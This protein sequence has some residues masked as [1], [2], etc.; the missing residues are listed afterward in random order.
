[1]HARSAWYLLAS[2][3]L[4]LLCFLPPFV[5]KYDRGRI[6]PTQWNHSA[7]PKAFQEQEARFE[8]VARA[9]SQM[10]NVTPQERE[11]FLEAQF[12]VKAR[13]FSG[14]GDLLIPGNDL[15]EERWY[16]LQAMSAKIF[17]S[18]TGT[19]HP[20]HNFSRFSERTFQTIQMHLG[21][22]SFD[23][24]PELLRK[25]YEES[26]P[27]TSLWKLRLQWL[28]E[29]YPWLLVLCALYCATLVSPS[30]ELSL[31]FFKMGWMV[32]TLLLLH[33]W[34]FLERPPVSNMN[35]TLIY[36]PWVLT[37]LV[38]LLRV[39]R[40]TPA[41]QRLVSLTNLL[42]LVGC[43]QGGPLPLDP[44]PPVLQSQTWL[45][46]HVLL[47][48]GS[49]GFLLLAS[50]LAHL[51]LWNG[52]FFRPIL[53]LMGAGT[54]TLIAGTFLGG[55]WAAQSWGRFWDWDPKESWALITI[56]Y[57]LIVI[58]LH[59]FGK[60]GGFGTTWLAAFGGW[61][62]LFTW[63]GVNYLIGTG[64]HSYGF[65]S[66]SSWGFVLALFADALLLLVLSQR[67]QSKSRL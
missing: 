12:P 49:Y 52:R 35:E 53:S 36:V 48:V 51:S 18:T 37:S 38:L 54:V 42:F 29:N 58:H 7:L 21:R 10:D 65:G 11:N 22:G 44:L 32:H 39:L 66:G 31:T 20:I 17:H 5:P 64:L 34:I 19:L 63:Y 27:Q 26:D 61:V 62:V 9:L 15:S 30:R 55:V 40:D 16:P 28:G 4:L 2:S 25:G 8:E 24:L 56:C 43:L 41:I 33:R 60:I 14:G 46:L 57:Y 3:F 47:I 23:Q 1:M 50:L 13:L 59:R 6:L 67:H 45:I